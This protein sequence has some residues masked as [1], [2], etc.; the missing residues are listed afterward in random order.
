MLIRNN[1]EI[2]DGG[3]GGGVGV[4]NKGESGLK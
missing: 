2:T 1:V 3:G 4:H